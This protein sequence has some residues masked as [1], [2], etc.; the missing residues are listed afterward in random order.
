MIAVLVC[1]RA[2]R[3]ESCSILEFTRVSGYELPRVKVLI[4]LIDVIRISK[5]TIHSDFYLAQR[6][7]YP[8]RL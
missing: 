5:V 7:I 3:F 8:L 1:S 2:A 6:N 4:I